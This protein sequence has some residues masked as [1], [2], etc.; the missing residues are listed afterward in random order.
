MENQSNAKTPTDFLSTVLGQT[1]KVRLNSGIDY[2]G[3]RLGCQGW[4]EV[5]FLRVYGALGTLACLDGY[6]NIALENTEEYVEGRLK[7]TYGDTFIR[8]NNGKFNVNVAN[9]LN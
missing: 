7:N 5:D 1:V 6:M 3:K 9:N 8:G 4:V 2:K